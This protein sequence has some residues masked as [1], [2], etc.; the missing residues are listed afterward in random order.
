MDFS[1]ILL[2]TSCRVYLIPKNSKYTT[3]LLSIDNETQCV[4]L[5]CM[6]SRFMAFAPSFI[7][8]NVSL[9]KTLLNLSS[10]LKYLVFSKLLKG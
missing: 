9:E 8:G 3:V 5:L 4:P 6:L 1:L 2:N 7:L 10:Q